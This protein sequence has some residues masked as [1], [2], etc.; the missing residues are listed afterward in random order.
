[1]RA[2][3]IEDEV[4]TAEDLREMLTHLEE[5][6]DVCGMVHS[7]AEALSWLRHH[8]SP[9]IV[10]CDIHLGDGSGFDILKQA[11]MDCPVI[12]CTA[13]SQ[14]AIEAFKHNGI[15]YILKPFS[16]EAIASAIGRYHK[17]FGQSKQATI[18][19]DLLKALEKAMQPQQEKYLLVNFKEKIIPLSKHDVALLFVE[20]KSSFLI[21]HDG[22]QYPVN[23]SL[24]ELEMICGKDFY[25][26]SRQYLV[27][28]KAIADV[29]QQL[30]RKLSIRL[31]NPTHHELIIG[32][33]KLREFLDW[34]KGG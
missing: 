10:F 21:T 22:K 19:K 4:M 30:N 1:M 20:G 28:R 8:D 34:L 24:E 16:L 11:N 31:H 27:S 2:L 12:F 23:H 17:L 13:Y 26:L 14:Y 25:R 7:V 6:V 9:D 33:N 15:D 29:E 18:S 5:P 32:K 3:I